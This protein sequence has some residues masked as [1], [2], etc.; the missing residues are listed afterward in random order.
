MG[1]LVEK[2]SILR[3]S[4]EDT[5]KWSHGGTIEFPSLVTKSPTNA[6]LD[7]HSRASS[8]MVYVRGRPHYSHIPPD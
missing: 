4:E 1:N 2:A 8:L 3:P 7:G 6:L 5:N